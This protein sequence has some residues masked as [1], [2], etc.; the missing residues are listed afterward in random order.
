MDDWESEFLKLRE[1]THQTLE[2]LDNLFKYIKFLEHKVDTLYA[3]V[4]SIDERQE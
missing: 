3:F 2:S 4:K 1:L